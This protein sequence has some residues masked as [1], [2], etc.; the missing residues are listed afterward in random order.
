M[1]CESRCLIL[2]YKVRIFFFKIALFARKF[3]TF[4]AKLLFLSLCSSFKSLYLI[5]FCRSISIC[6]R[7]DRTIISSWLKFFCKNLI[8]RWVFWNFK[9]IFLRFVVV[10]FCND[11]ISRYDSNNSC[12]KWCHFS[13]LVITFVLS[14]SRSI[15]TKSSI[16]SSL[17]FKSKDKI[18]FFLSFQKRERS[19]VSRDLYDVIF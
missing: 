4:F 13:R 12:N 2:T 15:A 11:A 14:F 18:M 3:L 9:L 17:F 16:K 1:Y 6:L 8:V 19:I 5:F 10:V 7:I